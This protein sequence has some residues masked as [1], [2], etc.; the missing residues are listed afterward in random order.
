MPVTEAG[1]SQELIMTV[2][3]YGSLAWF[4]IA[5]DDP[6]TAERFYGELFGWQITSDD[7][8]MD[9]RLITTTDGGAPTGGIMATEGR[10]HAVFSIAVQDVA[11]ACTTVE[12][13]GGTV[14][15]QHAASESGPANAYLLDPAGNLFGVFAPPS[16]S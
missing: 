3:A 2:P 4:E 13:L 8:G 16:S 11:A 7:A 9:Y 1:L 12:K 6:D 5:T 10:K 14:V 15:E